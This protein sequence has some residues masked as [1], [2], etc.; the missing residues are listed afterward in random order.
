M[1]HWVIVMLSASRNELQPC[2]CANWK[3][4]LS[5]IACGMNCAAAH[6]GCNSNHGEGGTPSRIHGEANSWCVSINSWSIELAWCYR[7]HAMNCN[8][9]VA[10]IESFR[11]RELPAAWIALRRI[12]VAIQ[13]ME[14]A[15]RLREIIAKPIHE[16]L[17]SIHR[18]LHL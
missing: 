12:E 7:H 5:W 11:F 8:L 14:K 13:I 6:W 3:L 15:E 17:T 1:E 2:G 18:K 16:G 4:S 9:A 10:W